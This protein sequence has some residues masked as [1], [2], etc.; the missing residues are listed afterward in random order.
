MDINDKYLLSVNE[1]NDILENC[2][3]N[4]FVTD[5]LGKIIFANT[6]AADA[7]ATTKDY[8]IGKNVQDIY[9]E[10]LTDYSSTQHTLMTGERT[11]ASYSNKNG[12]IILVVSTPVYENDNIV[13]VV[14]YSRK[15]TDMDTFLDDIKKERQRSDKLMKAVDFLD[16]NKR[17]KNVLIYKSDVMENLCMT[18]RVIAPT[19]S[20]VMLLGESGVGKEVFAN[21]IHSYSLRKDEIFI[22]IN[23]ATIPENLI[24]SELFGYEKGAFTG[25]S[26]KGKSGIFEAADK[27]TIFMD[28]I[29]ELPLDTQSKLLRVLENGEYRRVGS[30]EIRKTDV[31]IIGATNRDLR[32]MIK[33]KRFREDLY[34]RLNVLPLNI[35]PL[36]ERRED[37]R[38]LAKYYLERTNRRYGKHL[39][40]DDKQMEYLTNYSWPGN[41]REVRNIIERY[42]VTGNRHVISSLGFEGDRNGEI[43]KP[44]VASGESESL[45]SEG[46]LPLKQKMFDYE[47]RYIHEVIDSCH[48]D[49]KKAA[50]KL[51]VHKSLL[52]RKLREEEG[53]TEEK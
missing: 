7:L 50:D 39:T 11:V 49:I 27:G 3:S 48:G 53:I 16:R 36:R 41:V 19:D 15:Q 6:D 37:I 33:E 43:L 31:R 22:P 10:G 44:N 38:E 32:Q 1:Y 26:S 20:T 29:G 28:E 46:I 24:E 21:Y 52:Y 23:C 8:L 2:F 30:D 40:L 34:Y 51:G 4:I 47:L 18:A 17:S 25:A 9:D 13:M 12:E 14:T 35:P 45:I 42:I 5:G